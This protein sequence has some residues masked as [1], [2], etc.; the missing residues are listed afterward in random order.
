MDNNLQD[1]KTIQKLLNKLTAAYRQ[2]ELEKERNKI[3][4]KDLRK[5]LDSKNEQYKY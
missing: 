1:K 4:K 3:L 2:L 5:L